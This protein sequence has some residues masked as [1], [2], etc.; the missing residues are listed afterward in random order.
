MVALVG[1]VIVLEILVVVL[2]V[3][4][5]VVEVVAAIQVAEVAVVVGIEIRPFSGI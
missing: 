2:G 1:A 3:A 4:E 5:D